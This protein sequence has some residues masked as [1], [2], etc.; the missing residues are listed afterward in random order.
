MVLDT[1]SLVLLGVYFVL[2]WAA[3]IID[4]SLCFPLFKSWMALPRGSYLRYVEARALRRWLVTALALTLLGSV[5]LFTATANLFPSVEASGLILL[6]LAFV[7]VAAL[8]EVWLHI[9]LLIRLIKEDDD[10]GKFKR[11]LK[12]LAKRANPAPAPNP[13]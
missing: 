13:A 8:L 4:F 10:I 9:H 5:S 6:A 2:S 1:L 3:H 7:Y 11:K 12:K